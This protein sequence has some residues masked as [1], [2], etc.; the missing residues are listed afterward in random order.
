MKSFY[1]DTTIILHII[2]FVFK[3]SK[4]KSP[5]VDGACA[6][7]INGVP[8]FHERCFCDSVSLTDCRSICNDDPLCKGYVKRKEA[9]QCQVATTSPC[10]PGCKKANVGN[11]GDL[12]VDSDFS[13]STYEGC[14]VKETIKGKLRW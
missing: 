8:S 13:K 1:P 14:F 2:T 9:S 3:G 10:Q 12:I 7:T 4:Y 6:V 11:V 5:E